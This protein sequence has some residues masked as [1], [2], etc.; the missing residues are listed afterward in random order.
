MLATSCH[1][2]SHQLGQVSYQVPFETQKKL[3]PSPAP[4]NHHKTPRSLPRRNA[5]LT[6]NL[7]FSG[8]QKE[9]VEN[10]QKE[11]QGTRR[12]GK[13]ISHFASQTQFCIRGNADGAPLALC[14]RAQFFAATRKKSRGEPSA[15]ESR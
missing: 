2:A 12:K 7:F 15:R 1:T 11:H 13:K 3:P 4:S 10:N 9:K 5:I 8:G 6:P 14:K